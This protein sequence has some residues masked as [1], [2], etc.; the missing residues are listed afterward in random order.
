MNLPHSF[1]WKH[2]VDAAGA[3]TQ[4]ATTKT[5]GCP[6]SKL[7]LSPCPGAVVSLMC[8]CVCNM[9]TWFLKIIDMKNKMIAGVVISRA[10]RARI[11]K[12]NANQ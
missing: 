2:F 5:V 11:E 6:T 12:Q 3:P 10:A 4:R 8:A 1:E 9:N 7:N